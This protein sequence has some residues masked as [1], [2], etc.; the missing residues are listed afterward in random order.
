MICIWHFN[1]K[2]NLTKKMRNQYL[3]L[4]KYFQ[5]I[6]RITLGYKHYE[7]FVWKELINIHKN[8]KWHYGIFEEDKYIETVFG[9][10]EG[11][12]TRYFY[13]VEGG[14]YNCRVR[15]IEE[16]P[17]EMTTD[18]FVLATHFNN[19][20]N[21][22]VVTVNVENRHIEYQIKSDFTVHVVFPGEIHNQLVRHHKISKDVFWAFNKLIEESEEPAII[23]ADLLKM[24]EERNS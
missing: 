12:T 21:Y 1:V 10:S 14:Y 22:G 9:I 17:V 23:I 7:K 8:A 20:L 13:L 6:Y 19:L 3:K 2:I 16:Y 15:I 18:L 5:V 11:K 24:R 4:K